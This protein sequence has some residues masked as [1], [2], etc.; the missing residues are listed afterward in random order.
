MFSAQPIRG[1]GC[2]A[3]ASRGSYGCVVKA[4]RL[5]RIALDPAVLEVPDFVANSFF[6]MV[7]WKSTSL[8]LKQVM[9]DRGIITNEL[10]LLRDRLPRQSPTRYHPSGDLR[11][12]TLFFVV[13]CETYF[14][15]NTPHGVSAPK[16]MK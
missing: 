9:A 16:H 6:I 4:Q 11:C 2:C 7:P 1:I 13:Y 10:G 14:P 5:S 12:R 3:L 15:G 8:L